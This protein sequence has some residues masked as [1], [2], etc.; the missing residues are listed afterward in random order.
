MLAGQKM[1][2]LV[3]LSAVMILCG[4]LIGCSS[5]KEGAKDVPVHTIEEH[6]KQAASMEN[7]EKGDMNR[8]KKLYHLDADEVQDFV[9]YTA[10]SNV[11]AE[12][13]A[14]IQVKQEHQADSVKE[15]IMKRIGAQEVKLK[16]Y[17]PEQF[18]LVEKHVL[19]VKGRYILFTVSKDAEQIESAFSE[20]L[21]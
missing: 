13:L 4:I 14:V 6:I 15:K 21:K 1:K 18:Y 16:D 9:L 5:K 2:Y 3:V 17:R 19:K 20:A 8:L 12:E 11:E 7:M 10:E